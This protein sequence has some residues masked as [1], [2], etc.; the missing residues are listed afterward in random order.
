ML[1]LRLERLRRVTAARRQRLLKL[2][3][4]AAVIASAMPLGA[5][6]GWGFELASH[7]RVQYVIVDAVL[8]ALFV[9]RREWLW[10]AALAA[11]AA[12]SASWTLPYLPRVTNTAASSPP[13]LTGLAPLKIMAANVLYAVS[14]TPRLFG[15][16]Q[17]ASPDVLVLQEYTPEWAASADAF[18]TAYPHH[19]EIPAEGARGIAL[20]SRLPFDS[21]QTVMLDTM[22][23]IE[24]VVRTPSGPLTVLGVHLFSP[25]SPT[26]A[27]ARDRQLQQ[28]AER[29]ASRRLPV[30]MI[31]DLNITPYSPV[32]RDFLQQ[33]GFTDT[34]QGRTLSPSWPAFLPVLGIPIDHCIVSPDVAVV[35]HHGLAR[36]GSD[37]YPILA[38]L[39]LPARPAEITNATDAQ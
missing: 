29:V 31:G 12:W 11:C 15:I 2:I 26:D 35:A 7:F 3:A 22:P 5:T 33:T 1:A 19:V 38:E 13:P 17:A 8:L 16:V 21:T 18:R 36:F 4:L 37:H 32:Y 34:R 14:P 28:M 10:C 23:A 24:A 6:L 25:K 30:V 20:F 9:W 39:L 27:A